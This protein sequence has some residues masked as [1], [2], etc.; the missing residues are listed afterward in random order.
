MG[1]KARKHKSF[2]RRLD[3]T[4]EEC[5]AK[6][7]GHVFLDHLR[8]PDIR[9]VIMRGPCS[10]C[11]YV[12]IRKEVCPYNTEDSFPVSVHYGVTFCNEQMTVGNEV[13]KERRW[14][15]WD[16]AHHMD[17]TMLTDDIK[18]RLKGLE[19]PDQTKWTPLMVYKDSFAALQ[20]LSKLLHAQKKPGESEQI[21]VQVI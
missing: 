9:F 6:P 1:K 15:G 21:Y 19:I 16:Y 4:F 7:F 20:K 17:A 3:L 2:K 8:G 12:G 5:A 10:L 18:K 11:A 13:D 14:F